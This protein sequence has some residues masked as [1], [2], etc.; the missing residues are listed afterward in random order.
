[1]PALLR[2]TKSKNIGNFYCLNCLQSFRTK[3]KLELHEKS[4]EN[5]DFCNLNMISDDTEILEF[6]QY[7]K[8]DKAPFIIYA[9]FEC[10]L[11]K[12]DECKNSSKTKINEHI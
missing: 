11:E 12:I 9:D 8:I 6:N 7:Q 10:I 2:G 4:C 5:E 3:N 1:M